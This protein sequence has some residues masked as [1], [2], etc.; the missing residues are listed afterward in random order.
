MIRLQYKTGQWVRYSQI[1]N[2]A[3]FGMPAQVVYGYYGTQNVNQT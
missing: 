1:A 3:E 2:D